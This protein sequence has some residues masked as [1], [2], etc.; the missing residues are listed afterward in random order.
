MR[1]DAL[2]ITRPLASVHYAPPTP[3][4]QLSRVH[5]RAGEV[6]GDW[7]YLRVHMRLRLCL[8]K[9]SVFSDFPLQKLAQPIKF[10]LNYF[11]LLLM[12]RSSSSDM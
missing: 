4:C 5:V 2:I 1:R 9:H 10:R 7:L 3:V 11:L 6:D 12:S 8:I